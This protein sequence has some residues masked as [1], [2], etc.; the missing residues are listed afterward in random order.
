MF[1]EAVLQGHGG[2]QPERLSRW[3][4]FFLGGKDLEPNFTRFGSFGSFPI[5]VKEMYWNRDYYISLSWRIKSWMSK[6]KQQLRVILNSTGQSGSWL[7]HLVKS[8]VAF[9][10]H[11]GR[12]VC[13]CP[14]SASIGQAVME[15][16]AKD[17]GAPSGRPLPFP[18]TMFYPRLPISWRKTPPN[19]QSL[20]KLKTF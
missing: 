18:R 9:P 6:R 12:K 1:Q 4:I 15:V 16:P 19:F 3:E 2:F 8:T 5:V 10:V 17:Q 14:W 11:N 7:P 13:V 20:T